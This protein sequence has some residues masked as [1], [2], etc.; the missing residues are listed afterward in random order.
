ML[1]VGCMATT[2]TILAAPFAAPA[3]R[4]DAPTG[5]AALLAE[6]NEENRITPAFTAD[7]QDDW[8]HDTTR[9]ADR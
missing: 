2:D 7:E 5:F 4:T 3:M 6:L 1:Y 8:T 9:W